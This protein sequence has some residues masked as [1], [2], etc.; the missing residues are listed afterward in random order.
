VI[1]CSKD[2]KSVSDKMGRNIKILMDFCTSI[3]A[4]NLQR[5]H[6]YHQ[7]VQNLVDLKKNVMVP[8]AIPHSVDKVFISIPSS[9]LE[10]EGG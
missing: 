8:F 7:R 1:K 2:E 6:W 3:T 4:S 10:P 5:G 9:G